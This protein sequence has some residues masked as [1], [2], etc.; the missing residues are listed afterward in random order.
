MTVTWGDLDER[1]VSMIGTA[2]DAS[3]DDRMLFWN[4]AQDYFAASHTAKQQKY[5]FAA[6]GSSADITMPD[7]YI[8][9]Y[10]VFSKEENL[11]LEPHDLVPGMSWESASTTDPD[12][13][14]HGYIEWPYATVHLFHV[15]AADVEA[16]EIWYFAQ[17]GAVS[18][19]S[20]TIEPPRWA[21]EALLC[22][23]AAMSFLPKL[24]DASFLNEYKTRVDSGNPVQNP[25]KD[26]H[27]LFLKRY[28]YLLKD[29]PR[30]VRKPPFKPGGR[31]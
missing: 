7:D 21:H 26:A 13:E 25:L 12:Y 19:S 22:Y 15:P 11:L 28:E 27:D 2:S 8:E 17:Y 4:M 10:A 24:A 3:D 20:S 29:R 16:V 6:S 18:G 5:V 30:Q 23:A 1:F 9:L 14:P 31:V